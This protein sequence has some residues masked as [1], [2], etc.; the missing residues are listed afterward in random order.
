MSKVTTT[1]YDSAF[2]TEYYA[3][4]G[5]IKEIRDG[6]GDLP[7]KR[8]ISAFMQKGGKEAER[9]RREMLFQY[10]KGKGLRHNTEDAK[11][12]QQYGTLPN[13]NFETRR[14][15]DNICKVYTDEVTREFKGVSKT[16]EILINDI[17]NEVAYNSKMQKIHEICKANTTCL[18]HPRVRNKKLDLQVLRPE[19][20]VAVKNDYGKLTD[21]YIYY[22]ETI[23]DPIGENVRTEGR[24]KH[25][26]SEYLTVYN[27][28]GQI[29]PITRVI[30]VYNE[31]T[32]QFEDV[33]I[34][35]ERYEH[36]LGVI[37]FIEIS[38]TD[39]DADGTE[40]GEDLYELVLEQLFINMIDFL[41]SDNTIYTVMVWVAINL[42]LDDKADFGPDRLIAKDNV[43]T[44]S[45][46]A[47]PEL[48][49]VEANISFEAFQDLKESRL[50][51][52]MKKLGLP[53]SIVTDNPGLASSGV[54]MKQD[55]I[56]L[57]EIRQKDINKLRVFDKEIIKLLI[58]FAHKDVS[59][60]YKGEFEG[61]Y[62]DVKNEIELDLSIDFADQG[63]Y[64]TPQEQIE[65]L[66]YLAKNGLITPTAFMKQL[67]GDDTFAD[68]QKA[69][70]YMIENKNYFKQ[71]FTGDTNG[72]SAGTD[73]SR[74][75]ESVNATTQEP[76]RNGQSE[77]I[78]PPNATDEE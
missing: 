38:F 1:I 78:E 54:A 43:G 16:L 18:V 64:E 77:Q 44:E 73:E 49:N 22:T 8:A 33:T 67:T 25:W 72:Q 52:L 48:F 60:K 42:G 14:I 35:E 4:Y 58:L 61:I 37:P 50:K 36:G 53:T 13:S 39:N 66:D 12:N 11:V 65:R 74:P 31:N 69:V 34:N 68:D 56:E 75:N 45:G 28:T 59:S 21:I 46:L 30:Q 63:I 40:E 23:N 19:Q 2:Q 15:I 55:R 32:E 57:E 27:T 17:L 71:I 62:N 5:G 51:D 26:N 20:Y 70:E 24:I 3:Q 10:L 9:D 6:L 41:L 76:E 29:V 7:Y 47:P